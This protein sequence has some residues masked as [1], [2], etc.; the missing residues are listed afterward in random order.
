M[1][2]PVFDHEKLDVYR[3]A[4][5]YLARMRLV[6]KELSGIDRPIRDQWM[7][8]AQSI[9]L[10]IAEG[11]GKES[12]RDKN[13]FFEIARGSALECAAVHDVL[14]CCQLLTQTVSRQGKSEL[15]RVVAMLTRLIQ[16]GRPTCKERDE[17]AGDEVEFG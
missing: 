15:K 11:N 1:D 6:M 4:I 16:R 8:A 7:R 12:L 14:D 10:N 13:R 3:V 5:E 9:P 17:V 2:E